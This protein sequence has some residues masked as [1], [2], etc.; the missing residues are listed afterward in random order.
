[1]RR[2]NLAAVGPGSLDFPMKTRPPWIKK[3]ITVFD[4]FRD[5]FLRY[6]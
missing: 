1:M 6:F 5:I 3:N 2:S 4:G